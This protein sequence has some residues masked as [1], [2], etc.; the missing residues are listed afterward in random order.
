MARRRR[1]KDQRSPATAAL[2]GLTIFTRSSIAGTTTVRA[3]LRNPAFLHNPQAYRKPPPGGCIVDA[4]AAA[5][6]GV[7]SR[8]SCGMVRSLPGRKAFNC[9]RGTNW[10]LGDGAGYGAAFGE[11]GS[12]RRAREG[13]NKGGSD[14][15]RKEDDDASSGKER[16]PTASSAVGKEG[17]RGFSSSSLRRMRQR[18]K[19]KIKAMPAV[20]DPAGAGRKKVLGSSVKNKV[21][22]MEAGNIN[23]E[24]ADDGGEPAVGR[25]RS[26]GPGAVGSALCSAVFGRPVRFFQ[27]RVDACKSF[28]ASRERVHWASLAMAT[29]IVTTSVVPRLAAL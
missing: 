27:R 19:A 9:E 12:G 23:K 8:R 16:A 3:A 10:K 26:W 18:A 25:R 2:L 13:A 1:P 11:G 28:V 15:R 24:G 29:Y 5:R 17:N 7:T 21:D 14:G 20:L 22:K 6:D 4:V